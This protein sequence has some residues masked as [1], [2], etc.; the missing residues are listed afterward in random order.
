MYRL[1][2]LPVNMLRFASQL[3]SNRIYNVLFLSGVTSLS[4]LWNLPV[5]QRLRGLDRWE[6]LHKCKKPN[7]LNKLSQKIASFPLPRKKKSSH[8]TNLFQ[9]YNLYPSNKDA[10]F[11]PNPCSLDRIFISLWRAYIRVFI[12]KHGRWSPGKGWLYTGSP[13]APGVLLSCP[14]GWWERMESAL[15][16]KGNAP[17]LGGAESRRRAG[18]YWVS[19]GILGENLDCWAFFSKTL[20]VQPGIH[21]IY[22]NFSLMFSRC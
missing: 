6:R 18:G 14:Q 5:R 22:D 19:W 1:T 4:F 8:Q 11:L 20:K 12:C 3:L 13:N 2:G 21:W 7:F 9:H 16:M 15:L 10:Q 17:S